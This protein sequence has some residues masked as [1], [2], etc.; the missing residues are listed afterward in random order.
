MARVGLLI[1][2][3]MIAQ[4][5][6][7]ERST[8]SL[9]SSVIIFAWIAEPPKLVSSIIPAATKLCCTSVIT[10]KTMPN[11]RPTGDTAGLIFD[12]CMSIIVTPCPTAR[13]LPKVDLSDGIWSTVIFSPLVSLAKNFGGCR[14]QH[15][16]KA[17]ECHWGNLPRLSLCR[18]ATGRNLWFHPRGYPMIQAYHKY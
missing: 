18:N 14:Y 6:G 8:H 12:L 16:I 3:Y 2:L 15:C 5:P 17:R 13:R 11:L 9:S 7:L 4:R 10:T 1:Q